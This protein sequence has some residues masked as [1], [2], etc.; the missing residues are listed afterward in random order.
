M[1]H[2]LQQCATR[3]DEIHVLLVERR[4][5]SPEHQ[6]IGRA[7]QREYQTMWEEVLREGTASGDFHV[8]DPRLLALGIIGMCN[9]THVWFRRNGVLS[10]EQIADAYA[11]MVLGGIE[12]RP[13]AR[14]L[15]RAR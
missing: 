8:N 4:A 14:P 3:T 12:P 7:A 9:E 2:L 10:A 5:I 13:V 15:R 1:R 11:D 6:R